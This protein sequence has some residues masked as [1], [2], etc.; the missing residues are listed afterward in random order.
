MKI[1]RF[2]EKYLQLGNALFALMLLINSLNAHAQVKFVNGSF[3]RSIWEHNG[4]NY[5]VND[6]SRGNKVMKAK[7]FAQNAYYQYQ[8]WKMTSGKTVM[9]VCAGAFSETWDVSSVPV[10]LCVDNGTTV[11][12]DVDNSMD[13]LIVVYNGGADRGGIAVVNLDYDPITVD[14]SIPYYPRSN[15]YHKLQFIDWAEANSATIFQSQWL[16]DNKRGYGSGISSSS[17]H[18]NPAPRRMLAICIDDS[19]VVHH[20]VIGVESSQY[21]GQAARNV[22]DLIRLTDGYKVIGLINLDRGGKDIMETYNDYGLQ[23]ASG[24]VDISKATNLLV[25]YID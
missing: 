1:K 6:F 7:Y 2:S 10:G 13:A 4:D 17:N 9:Y 11:N 19:G 15:S 12:R 8:N 22:V 21:L 24:T 3:T 18:G 16:Y 14:G 25:Y 5:I 23:V 20:L